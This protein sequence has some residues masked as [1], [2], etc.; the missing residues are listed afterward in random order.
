[1]LLV[2]DDE[3][4]REL[5]ATFLQD[6]GY[7]VFEAADAQQALAL[8]EE[9]RPIDLLFT[10]LVMPGGLNGLELSREALRR[11]PDMKVLFTSG[12][13]ENALVHGGKLDDGIQLINK[14]YTKEALAQRIRRVLEQQS[15]RN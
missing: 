9:G 1:M 13:A 11:R 14:P 2:E 3:G 7:T 12:Y 15:Q 6:L 5:A 10:D 4:V 8:L